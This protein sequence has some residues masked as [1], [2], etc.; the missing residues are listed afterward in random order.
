M[1]NGKNVS[2]FLY[3]N[4]DAMI[5]KYKKDAGDLVTF[6]ITLQQQKVSLVQHLPTMIPKSVKLSLEL[7]QIK[8]CHAFSHSPMKNKPTVNVQK[9]MIRDI[10]ALQQP[11]FLGVNM[12]IATITAQ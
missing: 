7:G 9:E 5:Q 3:P 4:S 10:G 1:T 8:I 6:A 2:R 11:P 12:D